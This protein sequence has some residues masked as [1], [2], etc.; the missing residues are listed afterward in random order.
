[1]NQAR[2]PAGLARKALL[3]ALASGLLAA[4]GAFAADVDG[5]RLQGA[6]KEPGNWLSYHGNY[7][8]WHYSGSIRSP[9]ATSRT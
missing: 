9:R 2:M 3:T 8:S 1:M 5:Q 4:A 7:K 6:D